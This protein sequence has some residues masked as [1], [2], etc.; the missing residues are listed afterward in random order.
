MHPT[1]SMMRNHLGGKPKCRNWESIGSAKNLV[2]RSIFRFSPPDDQRSGK[3]LK[4]VN[5]GELLKK[6][7]F[8]EI[9]FQRGNLWS[10]SMVWRDSDIISMVQIVPGE[11]DYGST[12]K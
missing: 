2:Q 8:T 4:M 1:I 11:E 12:R 6:K 3:C 9:Q 10:I 7:N 5:D